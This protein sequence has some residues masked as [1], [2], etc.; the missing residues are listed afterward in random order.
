MEMMVS[1]MEI[2]L[3]LLLLQMM[4]TMMMMMMMMR[5]RGI[6]MMM[7]LML[8]MMALQHIVI[9]DQI[10]HGP[11]IYWSSTFSDFQKER[12]LVN[13]I[14]L[15][16]LQQTFLK[17]D[18]SATATEVYHVLRESEKWGRR[19]FFYI[20]DDR[21]QDELE[22]SQS[23]NF[24]P[25][26]EEM[27]EKRFE[28]VSESVLVTADVSGLRMC[29]Q[30]VDVCYDRRAQPLGFEDDDELQLGSRRSQGKERI[31]RLLAMRV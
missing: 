2:L 24:I 14:F 8:M 4:M 19:A 1:M 5:R 22:A 7:M 27:S 29:L 3:L 11:R 18:Q 21:C 23:M 6:V 12:M 16:Q 30:R 15:P 13:E 9:A 17:L 28:V 31:R 26:D 10:P 25:L 20:R